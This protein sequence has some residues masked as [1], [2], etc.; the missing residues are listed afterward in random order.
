LGRVSSIAQLG[1]VSALPGGLVLAGLLAD[2][3]G[4]ANVF[5]VGGVLVVVPAALAL[6][7]HDIRRLE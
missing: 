2:H 4:P 7:F 5:A 6:C 3:I 1:I